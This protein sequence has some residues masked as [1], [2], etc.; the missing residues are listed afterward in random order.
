MQRSE[1]V[2]RKW[3]WTLASIN[4]PGSEPK[5]EIDSYGVD[6]GTGS[7]MDVDA[8]QAFSDLVW[9]PSNNDKFEEYCERV[10]SE[11]EQ[12]SLSEHGSTNWAN[13][14]LGDTIEPNIILFS[15]GW[16]DGGYASFWGSDESGKVAVLAT[17]FA[18]F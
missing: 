10:I 3:K 6:S 12:N 8:A 16:G 17:D 18:L 14:R 15:S 11:L 5:G 1:L 13:L 9:G 4:D 7:F 2:T